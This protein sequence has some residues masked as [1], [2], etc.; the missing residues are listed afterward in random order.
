MPLFPA[1]GVRNESGFPFA[2]GQEFHIV[3]GCLFALEYMRQIEIN[4]R[5]M[6]CIKWILIDRIH[7]E[8]DFHIHQTEKEERVFHYVARSG[9][10]R[11]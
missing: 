3:A 6:L 2:S 1:T 4:P 5:K 10:K 8:L 11:Q 7:Y 9:Q